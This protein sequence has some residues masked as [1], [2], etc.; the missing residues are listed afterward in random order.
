MSTF[1]KLL[2]CV[3]IGRSLPVFVNS[4]FFKKFPPERHEELSKSGKDSINDRYT[5]TGSLLLQAILKFDKAEVKDFI[6]RYV[7][8]R[9]F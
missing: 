3:L 6:R 9:Y 2:S 7:F 8:V 4:H 5:V 1:A